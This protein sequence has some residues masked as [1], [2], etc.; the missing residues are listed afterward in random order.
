[1]AKVDNHDYERAI[2]Y[3]DVERYNKECDWK[4]NSQYVSRGN[5][6]WLEQIVEEVEKS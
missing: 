6:T 3:D 4:P 2:Y 5:V 1:M